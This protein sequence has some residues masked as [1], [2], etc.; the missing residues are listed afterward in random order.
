VSYAQLFA[1]CLPSMRRFLDVLFSSIFQSWGAYVILAVENERASAIED[2][3]VLRTVDASSDL[4]QF[5]AGLDKLE[6]RT[7]LCFDCDRRRA[8]E[9][10]GKREPLPYWCDWG[11][12][13]IAVPILIYDVCVGVILC[14]QKRLEGDEDIEGQRIFEEFAA[15]KLKQ[16]KLSIEE[17]QNL[18][19]KRGLCQTVT[20]DEVTEMADILWAASQ[21][22]SEMLYGK[23]DKM[24]GFERH[25]AEE[26]EGLFA[27]FV[28]LGDKR[29]T[30]ARFSDALFK[31]LGNLSAMFDSRCIAVVL[32]TEGNYR[33]VAS[34][35]LERTKL[36]ALPKN[37]LISS[38]VKNFKG[39]EYIELAAPL[40]PDCF[41]TSFVLETY[42]SVNAVLFD[43]ARLGDDRVLHLFVYF[44]PTVP[45][46]NRLFRHEK[47]HIL[48]LF[49]RE[50]ANLFLHA[51]RVE[52]LQKKLLEK[53]V[54]L[55]DV[56]HQFNQPL[57]GILA[58]CEYLA[59]HEYPEDRKVNILRY[60]P[61]RVKQLAREVKSVQYAEQGETLR[62]A[63]PEPT[64]VNLTKL[65]IET[66]IDFTGHAEDKFI[67]IDVD[68][69]ASESFGELLIVRDHLEMALTNVVYNA[70]KYAFPGTPE[71]W[72]QVTIRPELANQQLR[73]LVID[74]GIEIKPSERD[75]IFERHE[76]TE[77]AKKF[78]LAGLGIGLFVTRALMRRM[79]G[80]AEV[81]ESSPIPEGRVYKQFHEH[82]TAIALTLPQSV[83]LKLGGTK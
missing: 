23:L 5:C 2:N 35:G 36:Y 71:K 55:Q 59:C 22:I 38:A 81:I 69:V 48:S 32:E 14:G 1:D 34:H 43:K 64:F 13:E 28:E 19:E 66:A 73:I 7:H 63:K 75:V 45:P 37:S 44:D 33:V 16:G 30:P 50:T 65:L 77:L 40:F 25:A 11:L 76:R 15:E 83:V 61:S 80:N 49:L 60:L 24:A 17:L 6:L 70:V 62:S 57:H 56:V 29:M 4:A 46:H 26:L 51:E 12:R 74:N 67:T 31:P 18:R 21:F 41:L 8:L 27:G 20:H 3:R 72:S 52:Q 42:L 10:A 68:K 39:P 58:D 53:N 79:G 47:S 9:V 54:M 82:R 78:S